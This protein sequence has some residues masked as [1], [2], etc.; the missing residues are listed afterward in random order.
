MRKLLY[1]VT[2]FL[3]QGCRPSIHSIADFNRFLN[4]PGNGCVKTKSIAGINISVKYLPA[5][6][7]VLKS[8][9]SNVTGSVIASNKDVVTFLMTINIAKEQLDK[10]KHLSV[11]YS[12]LDNMS[13]YAERQ[14]SMNFSMERQLHLIIGNKQIDAVSCIAENLYELSSG[15]T[16]VVTFATPGLKNDLGSE[17]CIFEYNDPFFSMGRMKFIFDGSTLEK[18]EELKLG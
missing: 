10:E 9:E 7:A 11:M 2:I 8:Q 13:E 14:L 12:G 6:Y 1:I 18:I 3:L 5:S 17:M 4:D 16:F 15:K